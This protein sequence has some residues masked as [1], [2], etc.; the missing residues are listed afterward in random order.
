MKGIGDFLDEYQ[1]L[2]DSRSEKKIELVSLDEARKNRFNIDWMD[3]GPKVPNTLGRVALNDIKIK[4]IVPYIDWKFFFHSWNLSAK[5]QS[6]THISM[7]G[8]CRAQWLVGFRKDERERAQ[9]AAKLYNDAQEM[10]QSHEIGITFTENGVMYP[11]ASVSGLFFAHPQSK[12]FAI[13]DISK[14]QLSDYAERNG[15]D[16]REISKSLGRN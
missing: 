3:F 1:T 14:A 8:H 5:F 15:I 16:V 11:N 6:V 13:G 4:E 10:L 12:Y 2:R 9:E 7:C